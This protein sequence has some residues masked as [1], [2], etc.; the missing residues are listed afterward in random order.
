MQPPIACRDTGFQRAAI[1]LSCDMEGRVLSICHDRLGL[2]PVKPDTMLGELF[3]SSSA[4]KLELL[5]SRVIQTGSILN[6]E[7]TASLDNSLHPFKVSAIE[8]DGRLVIVADPECITLQQLLFE[9]H[10]LENLRG[11]VT[12]TIVDTYGCNSSDPEIAKGSLLNDIIRLNNQQ[13]ALHR[14]LARKSAEIEQQSEELKGLNSILSTVTN[15]I[16]ESIMLLT[17][18]ARIVWANRSARL[19]RGRDPAGSLCHDLIPDSDKSCLTTEDPCPIAMVLAGTGPAT[20]THVHYDLEGSPWHS[21]ITVYPVHNEKGAVTH[22]VRIAKDVTNRVHMEEMLL[23]EAL[24]DELT[25]IPNRRAFERHISTEWRRAIR[26][27]SPISVAMIDIDFF[28]HYNDHYGHQ[29]GDN[30]LKAVARCISSALRRPGDMASRYGG[31][32]FVAVMPGTDSGK[33][34]KITASIQQKLKELSIPHENS[35]VSGIV[36]V[37]IGTA[38]QIP[39]LAS[40]PSM[41]VR[42]ADYALYKAKNLGRNRVY[43]YIPGEQK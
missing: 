40:S 29:Q 17:P 3:D 35:T 27:S 37:S 7:C 12:Q 8:A 4:K 20:G 42:D 13:A 31:E 25:G 39:T 33:A 36:T 24:T 10:P 18:D 6:W 2:S 28:K 14:E 43:E 9:L 21:E 5:F 1:V 41:L 22:L 16:Q 23:Q 15:G 38:T 30:C 19:A 26:D 11:T 32:E 34:T